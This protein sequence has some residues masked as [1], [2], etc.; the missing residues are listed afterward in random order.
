MARST[1]S[2]RNILSVVGEDIG[3][4][5]VEPFELIAH[6]EAE[7]FQLLRDQIIGLMALF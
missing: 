6:R 2:R 7:V 4:V 5:L 1:V 3:H